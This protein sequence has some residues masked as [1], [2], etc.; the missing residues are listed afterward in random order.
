MAGF[1]PPSS[2]SISAY[3][4]HRTA[5]RALMPTAYIIGNATLAA[6]MTF[7]MLRLP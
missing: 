1:E 2:C 5:P 3:G 6:F 7:K 4:R